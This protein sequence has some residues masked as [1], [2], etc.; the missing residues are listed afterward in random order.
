MSATKDLFEGIKEQSKKVLKKEKSTN[1]EK[2]IKRSYDL[3]EKTI[4]RLEE[5]KVYAYDSK[6]KLHQIV[7]E[8]INKLY[9]EKKPVIDSF[10]R[11]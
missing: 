5:M 4:K 2:I 10:K 8:A 9:E 7:D 6:T 3:N 11:K 1:K